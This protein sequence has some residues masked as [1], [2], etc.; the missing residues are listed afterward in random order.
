[1]G[2][3]HEKFE[4]AYNQPNFR[5][6]PGC[7][8]LEQ[9]LVQSSCDDV[10]VILVKRVAEANDAVVQ[11]AQKRMLN[12]EKMRTIPHFKSFQHKNKIYY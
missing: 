5:F 12:S 10:V 7:T 11:A 4:Q 3:T 1:L 6:G 9:E 8:E 2:V